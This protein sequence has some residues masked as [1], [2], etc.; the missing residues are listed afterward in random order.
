[1]WWIVVW[2][3]FLAMLSEGAG[4]GIQENE[5]LAEDYENILPT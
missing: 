2:V 5:K 4:D 1:M 3:R